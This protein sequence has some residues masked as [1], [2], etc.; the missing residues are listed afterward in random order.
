MLGTGETE[1]DNQHLLSATGYRIHVLSHLNVLK[2]KSLDDMAWNNR[3]QRC[4]EPVHMFHHLRLCYVTW[5]GALKLK[6]PMELRLTGWAWNRGYS[7]GW[8]EPFTLGAGRPKSWWSVREGD[9]RWNLKGTE[10]D[11]RRTWPAVAAL[12]EGNHKPRMWA[13]SSSWIGKGTTFL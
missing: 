11:M 1:N 12:E 8:M 4:P 6:L 13:A 9:W 5:Q 2:Q 10:D 7:G 3:F